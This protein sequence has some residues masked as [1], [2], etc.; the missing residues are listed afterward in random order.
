[1][2][3]RHAERTPNSPKRALAVHLDVVPGEPHDAVARQLE[4]GVAGGVLFPVAAGP[5]ELEAV[6]LDGEALAL[7][8]RVNLD[9][10]CLAVD[11]SI[12]ARAC[13][14]QGGLQERFEAALE[15]AF[16]GARLVGGDGP[17][18]RFGSSS[19]PC[20]L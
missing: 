2:S 18:Q 10:A 9:G 8:V 17:A 15:L 20:P 11:Q 12:E 5:V 3:L 4:V 1:M 6:D 16:L 14:V 13:D 19:A 7:P